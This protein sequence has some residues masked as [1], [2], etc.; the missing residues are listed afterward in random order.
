MTNDPVYEKTDSIFDP[1]RVIEPTE[2]QVEPENLQVDQWQ[3]GKI[4]IVE[5]PMA[6]PSCCACC[7]AVPNPGFVNRR[8]FID[9]GLSLEYYGQVYF[10]TDCFVATAK[11]LGYTSPKDTMEMAEKVDAAVA[12]S[13]SL[14]SENESIKS[15][16]AA[17]SDFN[18]VFRDFSGNRPT[19]EVPVEPDQPIDETEPR[20]NPLSNESGTDDVPSTTGN[21]DSGKSL[22]IPIHE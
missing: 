14:R 8:Y 2:G 5:Y 10:C 15:G 17:I 3:V 1:P 19:S 16:L 9:W 20:V 22:R 6:L 13:I 11:I 18:S 21:D 7:G 4:Q 12:E